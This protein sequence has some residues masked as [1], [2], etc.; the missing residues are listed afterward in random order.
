MSDADPIRV[1][2]V[3]P[4][5][6]RRD[7]LGKLLDALDSQTWRD[8]EVIV[9]DDGST[10]GADQLAAERTVAGR[11]VR[12]LRSGG[13]GAVRART[14]G[15]E[16]ARGDILAFTDSDC[17]PLPDWLACGVKAID[18]GADLVNGATQPDR[19]V[20]PLERSLASAS[21]GLYPT[22]NMF[23]RRSAFDAVGGFD[24]DAGTRLGFRHNERARGTGFGEDTILAWRMIRAGFRVEHAPDAEVRHHVFPA[25][26]VEWL[27]RGWQTAAFPQLVAE[28]PELRGTIMHRGVLFGDRNRVPFY[29]TAS[30]LVL[31]RRGLVAITATWWV[32]ERLRAMRRAPDPWSR[33]LPL[34]PADLLLDAVMGVAMVAGS[35]RARTL[36]L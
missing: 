16:H 11:A 27:S 7:L 34:L 29:A 26:L 5:R 2:V 8:F 33:K 4:V 20:G 35:V 10:D 32:L 12:L 19:P 21:E 25:D 30:A 31:R 18:S 24:V 28:V 9:V 3:V 36:V 6:N 15:V 14:I 1:S 17:F 13:A 23:F 22:A